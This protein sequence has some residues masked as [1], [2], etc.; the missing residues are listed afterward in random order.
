ML[1]ET[2]RSDKIEKRKKETNFTG[3]F[4]FLVIKLSTPLVLKVQ[5]RAT[6]EQ[7][8]MPIKNKQF[9]TIKKHDLV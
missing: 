7:K 1:L 8:M 4:A 6:L 3:I 2:L 9:H 5:T